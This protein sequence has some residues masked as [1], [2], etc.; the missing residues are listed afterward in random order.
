MLCQD[1]HPYIIYME[2]KVKIESVKLQDMVCL[3]LVWM[4]RERTRM[5]IEL[6]MVWIDTPNLDKIREDDQTRTI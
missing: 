6:T 1:W 2:N 4:T 3:G 5:V